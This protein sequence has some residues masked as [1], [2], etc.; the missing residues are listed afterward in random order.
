MYKCC[1]YVKKILTIHCIPMFITHPDKPQGRLKNAFSVSLFS[2]KKFG[3]VRN[4]FIVKSRDMNQWRECRKRGGKNS[5]FAYFL[6]FEDKLSNERIPISAEEEKQGNY[7]V[8]R[9]SEK[10]TVWNNTTLQPATIEFW[11][12]LNLNVL[13]FQVHISTNIDQLID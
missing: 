5:P 13:S 7:H 2:K 1:D 11:I 4:Y 6:L 3:F 12:I 8:V 10:S 9:F